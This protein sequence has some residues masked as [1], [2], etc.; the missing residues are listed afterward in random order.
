[1]IHADAL[2]W[3][4]NNGQGFDCAWHDLWSDEDRGEEHLQ[5]KHSKLLA[6]L[7]PKIP[8]QGAWAFPRDQKRLW[9]ETTNI[10]LIG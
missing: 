3:V 2:E 5:L 4:K 7:A 6:E 1:M 9:R 8:M 10:D